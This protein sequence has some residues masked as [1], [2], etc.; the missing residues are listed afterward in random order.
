VTKHGAYS[1][2]KG[3]TLAGAPRPVVGVSLTGTCAWSGNQAIKPATRMFVDDHPS[4]RLWEP[5]Q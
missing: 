4:R 3:M 5:S 1:K 2:V